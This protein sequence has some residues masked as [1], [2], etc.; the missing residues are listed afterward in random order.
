VKVLH[1]FPQ[2]TPDLLNGSERYEYMLSS[3]LA[4][5]GVEVDLWTTRTKNAYPTAALSSAWPDEHPSGP[6]H[7]DGISIR[8]FPVSF[9]VGPR[10]GRAL[11]RTMFRR[12]EREERR[13]GTMV[14]GSRGFVDYYCQRARSRPRIY[15]WL[16]LAARGPCSFSLLAH[17]TANV[18]KYDALMVGFTPYALMPQ[19]VAI[20]A[21]MRRPVIIPPLFHPQDSY[22]HFATFYRC[23]ARADA[24]L[25]QT[26]YSAALLERLA[27]GCRPVDLGAGVNLDELADACGA[28]FRA[29][30]GFSDEKIVLF[31]GR[32]EFF[33]RYDLA[34]AAVELIHDPRIKLVMIGRDID[35]QPVSSPYVTWLGE[36]AH[37]DLIDAYDAC[38]VFLLPSENESFGMV[39]LEAWARRKPVIGNRACGPVACL[40][41]DGENGYLCSGSEDIAARIAQLAADPGLAQR[42]G[43]AGYEKVAQRYTWDV[44]AEK[45]HNLYARLASDAEAT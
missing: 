44:I 8:R 35:R 10:L 22:H 43:R 9:Q 34:I 29:K 1:I 23:F 45:V 18:R 30:Y 27:P 28:R 37:Q 40:I 24:V 14:R 26:P 41:E 11:S 6:S 13:L 15:D 39:F 32:K 16:M 7:V 42:L 21:M 3:K 17:L 20:G 31:V 19:A 38:E 33:K 2:F 12:W 25:A 4:E 36:L 5:R